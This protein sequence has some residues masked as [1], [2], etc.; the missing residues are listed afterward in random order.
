MS[1]GLLLAPLGRLG[2][3]G[4]VRKT[5]GAAAFLLMV[6]GFVLIADWLPDQLVWGALLL[7]L[8]AV[9]SP[10]DGIS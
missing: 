8:A 7:L 3:A 9:L 10:W 2:V 5:R 4:V 1:R 6:A